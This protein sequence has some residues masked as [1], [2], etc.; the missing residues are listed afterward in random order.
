MGEI[1]SLRGVPIELY[2]DEALSNH[3]RREKDFYESHILDFISSYLTKINLNTILDIGANIG[4]HTL[5]F[6]KY[7][8]YNRIMAFEP[9]PQ[10]FD[11]LIRNTRRTKIDKEVSCIPMALT[12]RAGIFQAHPKWSNMGASFISKDNS[13]SIPVIGIPLDYLDLYNVGF[14]KVDIEDWESEFII[15]GYKTIDRSKPYI[16][17]E[18][19]NIPT[20]HWKLLPIGY[21]LIKAWET[22]EHTYLYGYKL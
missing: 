6:H 1:V 4:N 18:D 21:E 11:L 22:P 9:L 7:L 8:N 20:K 14:I 15:G 17:L 16:L 10:N 13:P 2:S 12:D 5:Y 19:W 3:I